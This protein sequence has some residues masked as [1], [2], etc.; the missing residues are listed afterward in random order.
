MRFAFLRISGQRLPKSMQILVNGES[1]AVSDS[2]TLAD[3][4]AELGV[5]SRHVAVE[6]NLELVPRA[7]HA[8]H[9]L[10]E[11]DRLEV[12]TLVGGG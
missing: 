5:Q 1:R 6:V 3:L 10:R 9:R 4:L 2:A 11:G 7:D 12:V 8:E